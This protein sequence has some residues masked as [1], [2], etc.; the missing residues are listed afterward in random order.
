MVGKT[1]LS[2]TFAAKVSV[3]IFYEGG[4]DVYYIVKIRHTRLK[5]SI[6]I[7][8]SQMAIMKIIENKLL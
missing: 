6:L 2:N 3:E 8:D 4:A 1:F 5:Y 7:V